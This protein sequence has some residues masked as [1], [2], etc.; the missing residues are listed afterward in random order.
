MGEVFFSGG[1]GVFRERTSPGCREWGL[2]ARPRKAAIGGGDLGA[3]GDF[4]A[5]N[6]AARTQTATGPQPRHPQN[7]A[8][9]RLSAPRAAV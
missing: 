1:A 7:G 8:A 3:E 9:Q 6:T 5:S 4:R 2:G